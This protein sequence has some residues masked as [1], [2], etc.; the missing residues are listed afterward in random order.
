M[1][2]IIKLSYF[3]FVSLAV[4]SCSK[5]DD[6]DPETFTN[7]IEYDGV[8]FNVEGAYMYD[9]GI[10][11]NYYNNEFSMTGTSNS[12]DTPFSFYM[13]LLSKGT[14][15][16]R[17]G[18]FHFY[19]SDIETAPDFIMSYAYIR[20]D[21]GDYLEVVGGSIV[22]SGSGTTFSISGELTLEN[23][24]VIKVSYSGEFTDEPT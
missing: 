6:N 14:E 17:T 12:D 9:S 16:F 13:N 4:I 23:D 24:E 22:V 21:D 20:V 7:T 3:L 15:S 8:T 18:T 11:E 5:D 19:D 10:Y 2:K 1:K